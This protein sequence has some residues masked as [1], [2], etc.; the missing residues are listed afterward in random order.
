VPWMQTAP[1]AMAI[2]LIRAAAAASG[3]AS[4]RLDANGATSSKGYAGKIQIGVM[5]CIGNVLA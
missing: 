1:S 2:E 4:I 5:V 3:R